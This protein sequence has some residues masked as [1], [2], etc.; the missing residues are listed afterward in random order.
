M[1]VRGK[2][3]ERDDLPRSAYMSKTDLWNATDNE[4]GYKLNDH[5]EIL[6]D[7]IFVTRKAVRE[8]RHSSRLVRESI[9]ASGDH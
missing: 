4:K 7:T 5:T 3:A 2:L 9:K 8:L 1:L 6:E